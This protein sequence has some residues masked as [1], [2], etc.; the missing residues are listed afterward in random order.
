MHIYDQTIFPGENRTLSIEVARLT[1][2]TIIHLPVYVF[3]STEK[4]P[5]VLLTAGV[6]GDEIIGIEAIRM[7]L[8]SGMLNQLIKGSVVVIPIVNIFGFINL[9]RNVTANK[10]LNRSFPGSQKGS[11]AARIAWLITKHIL[12]EIDVGLDFHTGG[13]NRSNYPQ[14]RIDPMQKNALELASYFQA[15]FTVYSKMIRKSLRHQAHLMGKTILVYEGGEAG[16]LDADA[17]IK[18]YDGILNFLKSL[19]ML[20]GQPEYFYQSLVLEH[21]S[22]IR[23]K[24]SGIVKLFVELGHQVYKK[25]LLAVIHDP[26]NNYNIKLYSPY[27]GYIIGLNNSPIV[28]QGDPVFHIGF[29]KHENEQ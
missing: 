14:I 15:P 25:Q 17:V 6:H 21:S 13:G 10:D 9:M 11:L 2:G 26:Y 12:P 23:A 20:H 3:R 24:R 28:Y 18:A 1:S 27:N 8:E 22:W 29:N 16:R 19:K 7:L 4:G 5:V